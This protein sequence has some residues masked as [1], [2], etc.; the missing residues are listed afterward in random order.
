[1]RGRWPTACVWTR[2]FSKS[3]DGWY[4]GNSVDIQPKY[5]CSRSRPG[6]VGA[7]EAAAAQRHPDAP[8]ELGARGV[9]DRDD[10][11]A[12]DE[13]MLVLDDALLLSER[14]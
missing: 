11:P 14:A 4:S 5:G 3:V 13:E 6:V 7:G 12:P 10:E 1:M 9:G 8:V 2:V